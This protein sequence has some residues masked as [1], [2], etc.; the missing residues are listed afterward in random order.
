MLEIRKVM[1]TYKCTISDYKKRN[2]AQRIR[3]RV[4]VG[5]EV[6]QYHPTHYA[7][8]SKDWNEV[9]GRVKTSH[10]NYTGINELLDQMERRVES[11]CISIEKAGGTVSAKGII[12]EAFAPTDFYSIAQAYTDRVKKKNL[13]SGKRYESVINKLKKY[14]PKLNA[15]EVTAEFLEGWRDHLKEKGGV[16]GKPNAH[17]TIIANLNAVRAIVNSSKQFKGINP[18]KEGEIVVGSWKK[19]KRPKLTADELVKFE[20]Y[21]PVSHWDRI[22]KDTFFFCY[23]AAGMRIGD[24]LN[25]PWN[26]IDDE[27]INF[28]PNKT[29]D[30][31]EIELSIPLNHKIKSILK[32]YDTTSETVFNLLHEKDREKRHNE[33]K[34]VLVSINRELKNIMFRIGVAKGLSSHSARH[35]FAEIAKQV[36]NRDVYS[37]QQSL[38]HTKMATTEIYLGND[39]SAIDDLLKKVYG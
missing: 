33:Y 12:K 37:I 21:I 24:A 31:S 39:Q 35:T 26:V 28:D 4:I 7:V 1:A 14:R 25:L 18:F 17:N 3:L 36:S 6:P 5:D 11:A 23:Y 22:A 34:K 13:G 2:G 10:S 30:S 16:L 19:G 8:N 15:R 20:S 29:A 9:K 38:G 32:K 27:R